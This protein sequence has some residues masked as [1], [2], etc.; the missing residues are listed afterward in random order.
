[1]EVLTRQFWITTLE[2]ALATFGTTLAASLSLTSGIPTWHGALAAAISAG[3]AAL[4]VFIKA[5]GS[6]QTVN[7]IAATQPK[8]TDNFI[9]S[10]N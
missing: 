8:P 1:M 6:A 2:A 9:K 4:Y 7:A 3:L 5:F 10:N